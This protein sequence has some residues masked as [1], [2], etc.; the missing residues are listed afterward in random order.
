[1][2]KY[3]CSYH[4]RVEDFILKSDNKR[5]ASRTQ[6]VKIDSILEQVR[7]RKNNSIRNEEINYEVKKDEQEVNAILQELGISSHHKRKPITPLLIHGPGIS[8]EPEEKELVQEEALQKPKPVEKKKKQKPAH[9]KKEEPQNN[10]VAVKTTVK[11]K[12]K[13]QPKIDHHENTLQVAVQEVDLDLQPVQEE[14]KRVKN[15]KKKPKK[16]VDASFYE[17]INSNPIIEDLQGSSEELPTLE[18]PSIKSYA[19][20]QMQKYEAERRQIIEKAQQEARNTIHNAA[21]F[22]MQMELSRQ[23]AAIQPQDLPADFE[24]EEQITSSLFGEVDDQF[25]AF[26]SK[27]VVADRVSMDEAVNG[28]KRKGFFHRLFHRR[29]VEETAPL[30]G[31][32]DAL[33]P[34][35]PGYQED[36]QQDDL[37]D[38]SETEQE[39]VGLDYEQ[40]SVETLEER[41]EKMDQKETVSE[42]LGEEEIQQEELQSVEDDEA[43]ISALNNTNRHSKKRLPAD[44]EIPLTK[45]ERMRQTRAKASAQSDEQEHF[46]EYSN[47]SDAPM[48]AANLATMRKTRF[49]RVIIMSIFTIIFFYFG[50]AAKLSWALPELMNPEKAPLFFLLIHFVLLAVAGLVSITTMTA[51]YLGFVKEPTTDTFSALAVTGALVQLIAFMITPTQYIASKVTLFAPIASLIL[52]GNALGKWIQIRN[53]CDNFESVSSGEEQAA[54]FLIKQD[55]LTARLCAGL[56]ETNPVLLISRPTTLVKGFLTQSFSARLYDAMAQSLSYLILGACVVCSII[57]GI[58]GKSFLVAISTFAGALCLTAPFSGTLVYAI[59]TELMQRYTKRYHAIV[60]GPSAVQALGNANT[61]LLHETDLFPQGSVRFQG[62]KCF[63]KERIDLTILYAASMLYQRC[64]TLDRVF[65][66]M[67]QNDTHLLYKAENVTSEAGCGL[68]GWIEHSRVIIGNR[69]MMNHYH[70]QIP[71]EEYE[72][73]QTKNGKFV[74]IYLS[75]SG[76]LFAMFLVSYTPN[77]TAGRILNSL[78]RSGISVLVQSEDFNLSRELVA[79]IYHIS[80]TTVKVLN[81]IESDALDKKTAYRVSSD[82]IMIHDGSCQSFLGGMRGASCAA[83]GEHLARN[84]Q[85]I[86]IFF[87]IV[88]CVLLSFYAGLSGLGLGIAAIY[89]LAWSAITVAMPVVKRP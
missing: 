33:I 57:A 5:K 9:V 77:K 28:H 41:L 12:K 64:P 30:T 4:I 29:A 26:F 43:N 83:D 58:V 15:Q 16:I 32:Y 86:S 71:S 69:E 42:E 75:V 44:I 13:V 47:L 24:Q 8:Q 84:V 39:E 59:P 48:V 7:E 62:M 31:E 50:F 56:E 89:Q 51:G 36:W 25:R 60:P 82:G 61:I 1:M 79:Q 40:I 21:Q 34:G 11:K 66:E 80:P 46:A 70:V 45:E 67:L 6:D 63:A 73:K 53:I 2:Q 17:D 68:T 87:S 81:Q 19:D 49:V 10:Q 38:F 3:R 88:V 14:P 76:K 35:T 52:T 37:E 55:H 85:T 74:P 22:A 20:A 72:K 27:T 78:T 23:M 65:L 18:L 54:A